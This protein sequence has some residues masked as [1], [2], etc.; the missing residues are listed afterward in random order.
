MTLPGNGRPVSG[1]TIDRDR[2]LKSPPRSC[3]V[4]TTVCRVTPRVSRYPSYDPKK[5]LLFCPEYRPGIEIGPPTV[6][7]NW[8]CRSGGGSPIAKKFGD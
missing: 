5:K 8:F 2:K 6:P 3:A 7:P 1:S 4:A